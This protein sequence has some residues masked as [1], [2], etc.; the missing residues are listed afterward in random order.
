MK[1]WRANFPQ[2]PNSNKIK[3]HDCVFRLIKYSH[4]YPFTNLNV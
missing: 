3:S 1:K 4:K 2:P